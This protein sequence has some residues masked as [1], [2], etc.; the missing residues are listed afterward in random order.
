MKMYSIYDQIAKAYQ[1]PIY[2]V[3]DGA[4]IRIFQEAVNDEQTYLSKAPQDYIMF[5]IADYDEQTGTIQSD[6]PRKLIHG[7]EVVDTTRN[8]Q[9]VDFAQ[10]LDQIMQFIN[11]QEEIAQ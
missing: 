10:K 2:A 4:A 7:N 5:F 1:N 3:N 9:N 11:T 6:L 8:P